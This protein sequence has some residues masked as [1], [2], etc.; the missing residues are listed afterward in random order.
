MARD[1]QH[2][3]GPEGLPGTRRTRIR[4][5]KAGARVLGLD[6][7]HLIFLGYPD[8]ELDRLVFEHYFTAPLTSSHTG[9]NHDPYGQSRCSYLGGAIVEELYY[10][11]AWHHADRVFFPHPLDVHP[12]HWATGATLAPIKGLW[13]LTEAGEFPAAYYYVVHRPQSPNISQDSELSPPTGLTGP[14][15]HW[16]T[17]PVGTHEVIKKR[18]ALNCHWS[19]F[20]EFGLSDLSGYV[21]RNELFELVEHDSGAAK[22][23][24]PALGFS[25]IP[26][27]DSLAASVPGGRPKVFRLYLSRVPESG[28][29][30]RLY[31][32]PRGPGQIARVIDMKADS[33]DDSR[34]LA[35]VAPSDSTPFIKSPISTRADGTWTV[36]LPATWFDSDDMVFF[37]ADVRWRGK[38]VNHTAVGS[39]VRYG[40][41]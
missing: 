20:T 8:G 16:Y 1:R 41:P 23:D 32:W 29:T 4:E 27:I 3:P 14:G 13:H 15:H 5:A 38:L 9:V 25:P 18:D 2:V 19:L 12:D 36:C 31:V 11:I 10:R 30:Y 7:T 17:L 28:F 26:R 24:A 21:A 40:R 33:S 34:V 22:G 37:A 39:V 6:T 35:E